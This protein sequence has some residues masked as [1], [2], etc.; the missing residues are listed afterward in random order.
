ALERLMA[1]TPDTLAGRLILLYGP[2]GTGKTTALRSL[3]HAWLPWCGTDCVLDPER[4]FTEPGYLMEVALDDEDDQDPG[5][6]RLLRLEHC[7]ALIRADANRAG[8]QALWRLLTLPAGLPGQGRRVLAAITPN[9]DTRV[10]PPAAT[11]PGRC[12]A[13]IEVGPLAPPEAAAWLGRSDGITSAM[14]LA[15]LYAQRNARAP[16]SSAQPP[17]TVGLY[18]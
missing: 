3:A 1:V 2:P 17:A 16:I 5:L 15:E 13:Q 6:W 18:L 14:T 12:L 7:A 4:L 11:R 9:E 10:L 8:G